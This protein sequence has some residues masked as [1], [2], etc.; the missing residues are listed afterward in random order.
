[1]QHKKTATRRLNRDELAERARD[2]MPKA[3]EKLERILHETGSDVAAL[4]AFRALKETAYGKDAMDVNLVMEF[5]N[6]T[7]DELKAAIKI[8]LIAYESTISPDVKRATKAQVK[9]KLA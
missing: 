2:M 5:E 9:A 6:L 4:Q 1:M 7:D 3:M 8:E